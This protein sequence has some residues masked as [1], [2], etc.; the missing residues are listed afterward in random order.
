MDVIFPVVAIIIGLIIKLANDKSKAAK[1]GNEARPPSAR[2]QRLMERI[3]AQQATSQPTPLQ[4]QFTQPAQTFPAPQ[5]VPVAQP[6]MPPSAPP[7]QPVPPPPANF[8]PPSTWV[9]SYGP[10][11]ARP[12]PAHRPPQNKLPTPTNDLDNRIRKL[13]SAG[14]EV[15]AVRVLCDERD[16]NIIEA[17]AYARSL[18]APPRPNTKKNPDT[19]APSTSSTSNSTEPRVDEETRYVGSAAFAESIFDT[20]RDENVWASGWTEPVETDDRTDI[21][22]LWETVRNSGRP[23]TT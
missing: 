14:N 18:V 6:F 11:P 15:G 23:T 7:M 9:P 4:G 3:Q 21:T 1:H 22:E 16:M 12:M 2:V 10:P 5:N 19:N 8:L 17:Q 20:D 13:M